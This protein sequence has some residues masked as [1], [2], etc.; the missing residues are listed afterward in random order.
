MGMGQHCVCNACDFEFSSGHSHHCGCSFAVCVA[1]LDEFSL[2]TRSFWGPEI[3]E[4]VILNKVNKVVTYRH[5]KKPPITTL[6]FEPTEEFLIAVSAG[7]WGVNYPIDH[8]CCPSCKR[9]GV[10]AID[11]EDQRPCPK[12]R[13]G[14][15]ECSSVTY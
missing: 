5:K 10:I 13:T 15:I 2:P 1:C 6:T 11:F 7:E 12:C 9:I 4:L 3:G 8:M 14:I